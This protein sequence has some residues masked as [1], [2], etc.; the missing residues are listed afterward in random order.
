LAIIVLFAALSENFSLKK[1][2]Q[3]F[4]LQNC[5]IIITAMKTAMNITGNSPM[6]RRAWRVGP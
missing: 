1:A 2:K 6:Y 4:F 3:L 5:G